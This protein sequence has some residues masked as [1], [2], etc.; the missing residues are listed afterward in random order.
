MQTVMFYLLPI[1]AYCDFDY[2]SAKELKNM[3]SDI[4]RNND[5]LWIPLSFLNPDR[6]GNTVYGK[7]QNSAQKLLVQIIG[8]CKYADI[9]IDSIDVN[10]YHNCFIKLDRSDSEEQKAIY[11]GEEL[12]KYYQESAYCLETF[13]ELFDWKKRCF[14]ELLFTEDSFGRDHDAF[15]ETSQ[16]EYSRLLS[17]S[18]QCLTVLNN[19]ANAFHAMEIRVALP[20]MQ[21][22][23]S[24]IILS[25]IKTL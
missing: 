23:L 24:G 17:Q 11:T 20:E 14:P 4:Q 8:K 3:L 6:D 25:I 9:Q 5:V 10:D 12:L 19:R 15:R 21:A 16:P 1:K 2:E 18:I 7:N 22:A 13:P